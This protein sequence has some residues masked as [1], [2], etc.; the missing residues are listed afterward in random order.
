MIFR[1]ADHGEMG[2]S[3]GGLRQK[4][5][6][7][8]EETMRV[9]IVVSN[10]ILF[11]RP[12]TTNALATLIDL[13]PTLANLAAVPAPGDFRFLGTDLT[14]VIDDAAAHPGSPTVHV[15]DTVHF[16]FDDQNVATPNGQDI[17]K[18]PNHIRCIR[19]YRWKFV[20]YFDPA[21]VTPPQYE[22]Y[23]LQADPLELVNC[24]DPRNVAHYRPD[25]FAV[26]HAR[27]IQMMTSK[28]TIPAGM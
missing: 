11:P 19:D 3:H 25:Q 8:Y 12:V 17:V 1:V 15:Q 22:L 23:D 18:Q 27:L 2:L 10:P 24:A 13:M 6:N 7:A 5:F 20:M 21:W 16:T 4:V 9:P 26:M 14:P 28:G